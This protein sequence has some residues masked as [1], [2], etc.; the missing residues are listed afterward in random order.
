[1]QSYP[2]FLFTGVKNEPSKIYNIYTEYIYILYITKVYIKLII[3]LKINL[4]K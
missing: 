3:L 2:A 1:M 4:I